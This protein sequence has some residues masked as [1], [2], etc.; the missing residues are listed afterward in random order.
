MYITN[1]DV[2]KFAFS[3]QKDFI[4]FDIELLLYIVYS[5]LKIKIFL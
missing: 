2:K 5:G 3:F 1:F 4:S